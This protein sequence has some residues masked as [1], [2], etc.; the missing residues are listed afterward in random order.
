VTRAR[1]VATQGGLVLIS[2]TSF[3]TQSTIDITN[4]FSAAYDN[5][6]IMFTSSAS[7]ANCEIRLQMLSGTTPNATSYYQNVL[8][9]TE[10]GTSTNSTQINTTFA[11]FAEINTV[12][13]NS[14]NVSTEVYSPF[15]SKQTFFNTLNAS[16]SPTAGYFRTGC[17]NHFV[18]TSYS[19]FRLFTSTGTASGT[20]EV[21]GYK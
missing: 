10:T 3:T 14:T 5:Y 21:Y 12:A 19:G 20:I 15:L 9:I 7:S 6:K 2:S 18:A 4:C 13:G 8:G 11:L 16:V 17:I 1:D